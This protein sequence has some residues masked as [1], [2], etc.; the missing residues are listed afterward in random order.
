MSRTPSGIE[1]RHLRLIAALAEHGSLTSV[2]RMLGLTQPALSHQLRDLELR[3]RAPL[4]ERTARRMVLTPAGEQLTHVARRVLAEVDAFERQAADGA[5]AVARGKVRVATECYTVYHWLPTVLREFQNRWPKI[6]LR[7]TPEHT[8]SPV[9]ALRQG[10][11]DLAL[12][13]HRPMDKRIRLERLFDDEM[14]VVTA[15]DH[16]FAAEDFVSIEALREEHL[17]HYPW[18]PNASSAVRDILESADVQPK[19]TTQL[20]LTEAI[21][22]LVAAGFGVAVLAKW[23]VA[24]AVR[25]GTVHTTRLGKKGYTRT[26]YAAVRSTDVTP[27][28]QFDLIEMLRRHFSV[29]PVMRADRHVEARR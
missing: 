7:V 24:P 9:T 28:Y 21:L 23:A 8:A 15:P 3:L 4:F 5:F 27:A 10:A 29:G 12:V 1:I 26:W 16:R 13:Y 18:M 20:Q 22:E 11:L 25:A 19:N 6:E 2:A 14:V 17:I